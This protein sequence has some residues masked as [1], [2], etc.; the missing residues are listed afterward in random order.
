[1][2]F[3]TPVINGTTPGTFGTP[4]IYTPQ[5]NAHSLKK[6]PTSR[7]VGANDSFGGFLSH[8]CFAVVSLLLSF[9]S[10]ILFFVPVI[11][12]FI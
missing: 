1:M 6:T 2:K 10:F 7:L 9:L 3:G 4:G 12:S 5:R 11:L 8:V